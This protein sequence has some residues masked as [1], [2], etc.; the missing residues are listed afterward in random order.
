MH[1]SNKGFVKFKLLYARNIA[2][3]KQGSFLIRNLW[4]LNY[5]VL[6]NIAQGSE[7]DATTERK[8][9]FNLLRG[10]MLYVISY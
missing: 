3:I 4:N 7:H 1:F 8:D 10:D 6:R 9:C 5:F 2:G